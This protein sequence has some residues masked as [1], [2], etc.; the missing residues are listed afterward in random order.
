MIWGVAGVCQEEVEPRYV[1]AYIARMSN[2]AY[3]I[4]QA[5]INSGPK[6]T[7]IS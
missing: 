7:Q 4:E 3:E 2:L 6:G 1:E 5:I